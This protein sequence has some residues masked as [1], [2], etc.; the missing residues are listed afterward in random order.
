M[1]DMAKEL[2]ALVLAGKIIVE[3]KQV[4]AP[5]EAAATYRA[6]ESR[7]TSGAGRAHP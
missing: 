5:E 2:F 7:S 6:L 1:V 4:F 3:P